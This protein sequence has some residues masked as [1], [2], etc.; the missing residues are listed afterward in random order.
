M[1]YYITV[2]SQVRPCEPCTASYLIKDIRILEGRDLGPVLTDNFI[3]LPT[4]A[5]LEK[6]KTYRVVF[7]GERAS[8]W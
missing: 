4:P 6:G 2:T 8:G 3:L 7:R 5:R 1:P